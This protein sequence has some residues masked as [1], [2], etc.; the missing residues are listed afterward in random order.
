MLVLARPPGK[1]IFQIL[2]ERGGA[3]TRGP[4]GNIPLQGRVE[5]GGCTDGGP[6]IEGNRSL[7]QVLPPA[8]KPLNQVCRMG[9]PGTSPTCLHRRRLSPRSTV[10]DNDVHYQERRVGDERC[11]RNSSSNT[12]ASCKSLVSN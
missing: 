4:W 7:A 11:Q 2:D 5:P 3:D 8:L 6:G 1:E 12:L 10:H 9:R